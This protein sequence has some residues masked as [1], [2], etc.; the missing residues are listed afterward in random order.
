MCS[1][2]F[3]SP[4]QSEGASSLGGIL[5]TSSVTQENLP[6][7][8]TDVFGGKSLTVSVS[9]SELVSHHAFYYWGFVSHGWRWPGRKRASAGDVLGKS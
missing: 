1:Y 6:T 3:T 4:F 8:V 5:S 7:R 2:T 9:G